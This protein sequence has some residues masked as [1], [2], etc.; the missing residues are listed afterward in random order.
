ML[1][2]VRIAKAQQ[3][4][5]VFGLLTVA[6]FPLS[7]AAEPQPPS[8]VPADASADATLSAPHSEQS[9]VSSE[10]QQP[11]IKNASSNKDVSL[12]L[13][14]NQYQSDRF[15]FSF[16]YPDG[17]E[18]TV[19][20]PEDSTE[21]YIAL[22]RQE[23][24]GDPEPPFIGISVYE[25]PQQF[26][27]EGFREDKGYYI[28]NEFPDISVA[29]QRALDFEA[30]GLYES[31]EHLFKTPEGDHVVSLS[32]TYLDMVSEMDPLWQVAQTL[33]D[34]FEWRSPSTSENLTTVVQVDPFTL[35]ELFD[36]GGGGCGMSLLQ[37]NAAPG[38]GFL[39]TNGI[40]DS[41]ALM[42]L[43]GQWVMLNRTAASG[44][45]FYGQQTSQTFESEDGTV[46]VQIDVSLGAVGEIESVEFADVQLQV[47][48]DTQV[49]DVPAVGGAGC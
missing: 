45:E 37:P 29:E 14:E 13:G 28:L 49:V 21:E 41:P 30:A 4:L 9:P 31:R 6:I 46:T 2:R 5:M 40:D 23:D 11:S 16:T 35:D 7:C 36:Q 10:G 17:F 44:E 48:Q 26:S 8:P 3:Q 18:L 32:A 42:K 1:S 43:D 39:F 38:E 27:L 34:S 24:V 19:T 22:I 15:G 47:I 20:H 33:R 25:N 12:A